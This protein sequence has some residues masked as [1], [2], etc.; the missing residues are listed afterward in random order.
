MTERCTRTAVMCRGGQI[1]FATDAVYAR[2]T[3]AMRQRVDA[4]LLAQIT[5]ADGNLV[6]IRDA[7]A[8]RHLAPEGDITLLAVK[9]DA[10][11]AATPPAPEL[12][13]AKTLPTGVRRR[14]T[15]RHR[16]TG[17][18]HLDRPRSPAEVTQRDADVLKSLNRIGSNLVRGGADARRHAVERYR[19]M[20]HDVYERVGALDVEDFITTTLAN[21]SVTSAPKMF[22]LLDALP[23]MAAR[24]GAPEA[25][26]TTGRFAGDTVER[27][28]PIVGRPPARRLACNPY[29]QGAVSRHATLR[30]LE[31]F[32][33]R[34]SAEHVALARAVITAT[35][36]DAED[37]AFATLQQ[38]L[39]DAGFDSGRLDKVRTFIAS[40]L[41]DPA[42][43]SL[44]D[45]ARPVFA[46][47]GSAQDGYLR[48]DVPARF[49]GGERTVRMVCS[50]VAEHGD[51]TEVAVVTCFDPAD[52]LRGSIF[53][54]PDVA[55][56]VLAEFNAKVEETLFEALTSLR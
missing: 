51:I 35:H 1:E 4:A 43:R 3:D 55:A 13:D 45:P 50:T 12:F 38:A 14:V 27:L 21:R 26:R 56:D 28:R 41:H 34:L 48:L 16:A 37:E 23:S 20:L 36:P 49:G 44:D 32:D 30:F 31:R 47:S 10:G 40:R 33:G 7:L 22:A 11:G 29:K 6:E 24:V 15:D 19:V 2:L 17:A 5:T 54:L 52:T 18:G 25:G 53:D 42:D 46:P 8:I 39:A 9:R